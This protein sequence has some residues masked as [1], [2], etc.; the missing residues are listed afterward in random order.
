MAAESKVRFHMRESKPK[1]VSCSFR[2]PNISDTAEIKLDLFLWTHNCKSSLKSPRVLTSPGQFMSAIRFCRRFC[3]QLGLSWPGTG[4]GLLA[5]WLGQALL[6]SL[7]IASDPA[8]RLDF[9]CVWLLRINHVLIVPFQ[10]PR[11]IK[12][13]W[14][15]HSQDALFCTLALVFL[16]EQGDSNK[17]WNPHK[18]FSK[19]KWVN[20]QLT[21]VLTIPGVGWAS[22]LLFI[23]EI[24]GQPTSAFDFNRQQA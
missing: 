7:F 19:T 18:W 8:G 24:H 14:V 10:C 17:I 23:S 11:L 12:A 3:V 6:S 21:W 1:G 20:V 9:H 13:W 4:W 5:Q 22:T 16:K 2:F 15:I